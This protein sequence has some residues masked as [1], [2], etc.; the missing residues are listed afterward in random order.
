VKWNVVL[1]SL[2]ITARRDCYVICWS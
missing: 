2:P 1:A